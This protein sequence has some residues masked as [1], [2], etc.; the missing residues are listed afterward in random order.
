MASFVR[1]TGQADRYKDLEISYIDHHNPDLVLFDGSGEEVQRIDL[2]R[3]RTLAN[4]HKLLT[5][6]G[7]KELCRDLNDSCVA[8]KT[9]GQCTANP[10]YMHTTCRAACGLCSDNATA[11]TSV[12]C[13][14][15]SPDRDC[16]Y[17]STIGECSKNPDFMG[18]ACKRSCGLCQ[19]DVKSDDDDDDEFK[20]EL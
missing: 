20:D 9:S 12:Q 1:D 17:W 15:A 3:I 11:D 6:L 8:W 7:M 5:M 19:P 18:T 4:I 10:G 2:T 13:V 14:N 16:E